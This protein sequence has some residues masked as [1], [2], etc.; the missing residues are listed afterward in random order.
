MRAYTIAVAALALECDIKWLD[1]LLSHHRVPGI[2]R[3]RQGVQRQ[4]P[5]DSLLVIGVARSLIDSLD[6][7]IAKAIALSVLLVESQGSVDVPPVLLQ[8]DVRR[9][10]ARLHDRLADAVEGAAHL[11]RG[12][13]K[14]QQ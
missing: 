10:S 8:I 13:P 7:P 14:T 12:R 4:I 5:P 1:N 6:V 2:A 3:K 9:I 11:P